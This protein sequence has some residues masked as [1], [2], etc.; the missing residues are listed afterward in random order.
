MKT[1]CEMAHL[2][3]ALQPPVPLGEPLERPLR[4]GPTGRVV[5]EPLDRTQ[6]ARVLGLALLPR[7]RTDA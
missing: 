2:V 6:R 5:P 3:I 7:L 1:K 4:L